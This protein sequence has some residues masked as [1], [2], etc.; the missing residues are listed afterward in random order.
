MSKK[1]QSPDGDFFDPAGRP[2]PANPAIIVWSQSPDGDFFDPADR[3]CSAGVYSSAP[4]QSP[5][6]DFFD[7]AFTPAETEADGLKSQ[8]PDGDFFDPALIAAVALLALAGCHSPLTGI[9]LIRRTR[10]SN[11]AS[12]E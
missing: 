7:P 10:S 9:F 8:S 2:D 5:D 11:A 6:G 1:S 4:S 3:R 12:D